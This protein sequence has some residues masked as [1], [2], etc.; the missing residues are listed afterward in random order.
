MDEA[1]IRALPQQ[2]VEG[3]APFEARQ[4]GAEAVM[5]AEPEGEMAVRFARKIE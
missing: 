4:W 5:D 3:D 2:H 1:Q